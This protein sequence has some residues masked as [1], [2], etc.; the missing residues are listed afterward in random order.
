MHRL[1]EDW[2]QSRETEYD[3]LRSAWRRIERMSIGANYQLVAQRLDRAQRTRAELA[4]GGG[5]AEARGVFISYLRQLLDRIIQN[6]IKLWFP[7]AA[8]F[9]RASQWPGH[10]LHSQ[11]RVPIA[12]RL[13]IPMRPLGDV[14][15]QKVRLLELDALLDGWGKGDAEAARILDVEQNPALSERQYFVFAVAATLA[16]RMGLWSQAERYADL[17][18][19]SANVVA[20]L[21]ITENAARDD[22]AECFYLKA[23]ATRFR[24][25][26]FTPYGSPVTENVWGRWL[27]DAV[28]LLDQCEAQHREQG[29][30]LRELRAV[31]ERAALRLFYAT[32]IAVGPPVPSLP[33]FP[34]DEAF[35]QLEASA[36][37]LR[38]CLALEVRARA[39]V[40]QD[41]QRQAFFKRLER[42]YVTNC[43]A[44]EVIAALVGRNHA[45]SVPVGLV[46]QSDPLMCRI[47]D[48]TQAARYEGMPTV[49]RVDLSAFL[50][51]RQKDQKAASYL[52]D[53]SENR[54]H[55]PTL[56][57][58]QSVLRA[59]LGVMHGWLHDSPIATS[60]P[61][62]GHEL[63]LP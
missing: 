16:L 17:A 37:D 61:D 41:V 43:A 58:D 21:T 9:I 34:A 63:N 57:I 12:L 8:D 23:V 52:Q 19:S 38:H 4:A 46:G 42:Q 22:M 53:L 6:S 47:L 7:L 30:I 5:A 55:W 24:L 60:K 51:L 59:I 48:W 31:S 28:A 45:L 54:S 27:R 49:A 44:A 3:A 15:A 33:F 39:A 56:A 1:D 13:R 14:D 25:G 40:E 2:L 35:C 11:P 10:E 29:Q 20:A 18:S 62:S 32:W 36:G 50:V 26:A